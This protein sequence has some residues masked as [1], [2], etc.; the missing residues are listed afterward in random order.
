MIEPKPGVGRH[1]A[2]IDFTTLPEPIPLAHTVVEQ[3]AAP[4]VPVDGSSDGAVGG[5]DGGD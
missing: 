3:P 5:D 1:A 4:H 2:D